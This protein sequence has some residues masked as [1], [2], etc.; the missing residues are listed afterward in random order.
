MKKAIILAA[1]LGTRLRPLTNDNPKCLV[2][3]KGIPLIDIWLN[4]LD[5]LGVEDFL[6]NTHYLPEKV[7]EHILKSKFKDRVKLIHENKLMGT[8]GTLI[9]NIDF[10]EN[11]DGLIMHGDNF[12]SDDLKNFFSVHHNRPKEC[13]MTMMLFRTNTPSSSG[14]VRLNDNNIVTHFYEKVKD[15]P[16]NLANGAIYIITKNLMNILKD[17][18][19]ITDISTQLIPMLLGKIMTYETKCPYVDIGNINSYNYANKL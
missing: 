5:R 3:I 4:K 16:S 1:G 15:P 19:N 17:K 13:L 18:K 11:N 8:A 2:T 10:Y 9:K 12:T 7:K 14:I 6:I